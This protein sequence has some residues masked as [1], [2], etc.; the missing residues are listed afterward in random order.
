MTIVDS[1]VK[2]AFE[3]PYV[4]CRH[5]SEDHFDRQPNNGDTQYDYSHCAAVRLTKT[6]VACLI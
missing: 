3:L 6:N 5:E 2:K 1:V 4:V